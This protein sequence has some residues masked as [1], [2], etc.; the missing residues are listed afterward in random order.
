MLLSCPECGKSVSDKALACPGCGYPVEEMRKKNMLILFDPETMEGETE[1]DNA[2]IEV[3]T[4]FYGEL[5]VSGDGRVWN[6]GGQ[7]VAR[8]KYKVR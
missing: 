3:A 1:S 7:V 4:D 5:L 2:A 6:D 8:M